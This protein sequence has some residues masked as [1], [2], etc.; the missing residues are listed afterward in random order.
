MTTMVETSLAI[1]PTAFGGMHG[2]P[3]KAESGPPPLVAGV[4]PAIRV[5]RPT[6]SADRA[7]TLT[8]GAI[9]QPRVPLLADAPVGVMQPALV[10]GVLHIIFL[11]AKEQMRWVYAGWSIAFV[12]HAHTVWYFANKQCPRVAMS[13]AAEQSGLTPRPKHSIPLVVHAP[14]P[15]PALDRIC[16]WNEAHES[17]VR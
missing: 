14:L 7:P 2:M 17:H 11:R 3:A 6:T 15:Q 1:A 4:Q 16:D 8:T 12:K 5:S 13:K 9:F 10:G